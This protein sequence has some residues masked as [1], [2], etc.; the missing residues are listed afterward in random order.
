MFLWYS[1]NERYYE[2]KEKDSNIDEL[3]LARHESIYYYNNHRIK[4]KL[5]GLSPVNYRL[6]SAKVI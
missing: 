5:K 2:Q 3:M 1:K 6:Q 4:V